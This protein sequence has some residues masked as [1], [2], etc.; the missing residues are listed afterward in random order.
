MKKDGHSKRQNK[1]KYIQ[2][3]YAPDNGGLDGFICAHEI[4]KKAKNAYRIKI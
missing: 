4:N 3:G 2:G 1:C